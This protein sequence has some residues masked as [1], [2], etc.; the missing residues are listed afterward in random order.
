MFFNNKYFL[1]PINCRKFI[2][3]LNGDIIKN[4][5]VKEIQRVNE[6]MII[7]SALAHKFINKRFNGEYFM[8]KGIRPYNKYKKN[9]NLA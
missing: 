2:F 4:K 8:T 1:K 6:L 5:E 7:Y 9:I 3:F